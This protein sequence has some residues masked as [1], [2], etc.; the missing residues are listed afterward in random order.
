MDEAD[1]VTITRAEYERL[2]E[3]AEDALDLA[4]VDAH[5]AAEARGEA[6]LLPLEVVDRILAGEHPLRVIREHRGL[7]QVQLAT[8]AGVGRS[9]LVE[10][11]GG[12]KP[13]SADTLARLA[14]ALGVTIEDILP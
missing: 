9:Y 14:R 8:A 5:R 12:R 4:A 6:M 10:I 7:S 3:L 1:T 11:E 2:L 13:G